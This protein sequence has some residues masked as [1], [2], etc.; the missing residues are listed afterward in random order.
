MKEKDGESIPLMDE[1]EQFVKINVELYTLRATGVIARVVSSILSNLV[2]GA[3]AFIFLFMLAMGL[4]F[5]IGDKMGNLYSG[6][7]IMGGAFAV[8]T[9]II[10]LLRYKLIRKPVMNGMITQILKDKHHA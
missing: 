3:L 6:F 2:I 7:L 10:Y 4:A 8:I 5:W 9:I 1:V